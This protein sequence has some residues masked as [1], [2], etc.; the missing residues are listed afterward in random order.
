MNQQTIT[1]PT[2]FRVRKHVRK[3][4]GGAEVHNFGNDEAAARAFY[5]AVRGRGIPTS[6][7]WDGD[8]APKS[9]D[10]KHVARRARRQML[11]QNNAL[12][13]M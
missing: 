13:L 11:R 6:L 9:S 1:A 4:V 7:E 10:P 8:T 12:R 2:N 3:K 5:G